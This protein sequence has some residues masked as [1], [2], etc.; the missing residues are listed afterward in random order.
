MNP[1]Y[2]TWPEMPDPTPTTKLRPVYGPQRNPNAHLQPHQLQGAEGP[3][4][5]HREASRK[6][7]QTYRAWVTEHRAAQAAHLKT[8]NE[9]TK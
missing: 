6:R 4:E 1:H 9:E 3:T 2:D 7:D 5:E 8:L